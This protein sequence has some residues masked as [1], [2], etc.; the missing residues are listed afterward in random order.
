M[1][2][3]AA[4]GDS[5]RFKR[6]RTAGAPFGLTPRRY[7]SCEH[8]NPGRKSKAGD[9]GCSRNIIR[10]RQRFAQANN[11]RVADQIAGHAGDARKRASSRCCRCRAQT[12]RLAAPHVDRQ[13]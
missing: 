4:V 7:R 13:H 10:N 5:T 3:K 9:R 6:S 12:R 2:F 11:G 1:T 8:G